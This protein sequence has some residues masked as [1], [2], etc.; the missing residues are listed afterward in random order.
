[1]FN[2]CLPLWSPGALTTRWVKASE[3]LA[4]LPETSREAIDLRRL[5]RDGCRYTSEDV[6]V[7]QAAMVAAGLSGYHADK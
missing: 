2:Y 1:V 6:T 7:M 5:M 4:L 3:L